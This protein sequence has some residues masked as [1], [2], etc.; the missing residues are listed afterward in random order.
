M[1]KKIR[2]RETGLL[3][4]AAISNGMAVEDLTERN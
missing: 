2:E 3:E 4:V 1:K